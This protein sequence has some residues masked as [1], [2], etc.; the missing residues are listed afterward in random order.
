MQYKS[1]NF[2][3]NSLLFIQSK[4]FFFLMILSMPLALAA[5]NNAVI[6][7]NTNDSLKLKEINGF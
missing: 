3:R 6:L 1:N 5:Q 2:I 4:I 7:A